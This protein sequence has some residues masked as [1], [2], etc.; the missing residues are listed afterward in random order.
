MK[1]TVLALSCLTAIAVVQ[2]TAVAQRGPATYFPGR[3]DWQHKTPDEVGMDPARVNAAVAAAVAA[4][5]QTPRDQALAQALSFGRTEPFDTIIGPM[6]PRGPASGL[7]VR[8]GYIVAEWG[9][10]G[11]VD[12]THSVTKTFCVEGGRRGPEPRVREGAF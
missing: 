3:F 11:R 2:S 4:E 6:K 1:R 7:I 8:H 9:E 5:S 10:P 12:I